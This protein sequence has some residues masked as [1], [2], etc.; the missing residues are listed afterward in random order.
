MLNKL[1]FASLL[2]L[3]SALN[4]TTVLQYSN[5]QYLTQ[6]QL[7]LYNLTDPCTTLCSSSFYGEFCQ[8]MPIP[9]P[10]GPWNQ[11]G[12][13]L[14]GP[15]IF[16]TLTSLSVS[17]LYQAQFIPGSNLILGLLNPRYQNS[18]LMQVSYSAG[19]VTPI[20]QAPSGTTLD[21]LVVRG[22]VA[23]LARSQGST[24]DV[25]TSAGQRLMG[26]SSQALLLEVSLDKGLATVFIINAAYNLLACYPNGKCVAWATYNG[27]T[28][29]LCGIDCPVSVY[30]TFTTKLLKL[31]NT[32]LVSTAVQDTSS[33]FCAAVDRALNVLVYK[34]GN[35]LVQVNLATMQTLSLLSLP[36]ASS[37]SMDISDGYT[38]IMLMQGGTTTTL[39][40]LQQVCGYAQTSPAIYANSS[41]LCTPCPAPPD[42]AFI[43]V[44]SATC[45]WRCSQGY[46]QYG[47]LCVAPLYSPCPAYYTQPGCLPATQPWAPA[48]KYLTGLTVSSQ[49]NW[50]VGSAPPYLVTAVQSTTYLAVSG[51]LYVA[52]NTSYIPTRMTLTVPSTG[53]ICA[54][55]ANNAYYLLQAQ[56]GRLLVAFNALPSNTNCLWS[57]N[58]TGLR[59]AQASIWTLGASVCSVAYGSSGYVYL[60]FCS[61]HYIAQLSPQSVVSPLAGGLKAGYADG[62]LLQ[63]AFN[64]PSSMASYSGRLYVADTRNCVIREVD[65]Y[66]GSVRTVAGTQGFCQRV[67]GALAGL[68]YPANLTS[69]AYDGFLLFFDQYPSERSPTARQ[70]HPAS[71]VVQSIATPPLNSLGAASY[72]YLV[73]YQDRILAGWSNYYF[74]VTA[75]SSSCP[76]GYSA[77]PGNALIAGGCLPCGA[78]SY[79]NTSS[80]A[81]MQCSS[82]SCSGAGQVLT[83]C[84]LDRDAY[85][86]TCSNKPGTNTVYTG[87]S[88]VPA[89]ASG[90]GG[91]CPWTYLPP[92]P[93]GYYKASSICMP[94]PQWS[95]TAFTGA[96][97]V[98]QCTCMAGGTGTAGSCVIPSPFSRTPTVC[99]ALSD[100]PTYTEPAFPF[101]LLSSCQYIPADSPLYV[102]PCPSG[103][104][105]QQIYPKIC[106][107]C[108]PGLFSPL[109]RG[110]QNCPYIMEP[111]LDQ[112]TCRCS[113][114]TWDSAASNAVPQCMCGP[115]M[116]LDGGG[117]TACP[118]NTF[119]GLVVQ[120]LQGSALD[121]L[122]CPAGTFSLAGATACSACAFGEFRVDEDTCQAC[123]AGSYAPD[124]SVANCAPCVSG[125]DG[126]K[127]EACPT[128]PSLLVCSECAPP[129]ANSIQQGLDCATACLDGFYELDY[130]CS[131][132]TQFNAT[133][134]PAG[135]LYIPCTSYADSGCVAC[136]NDTMPLNFAEWAYTPSYPDGPN[137]GCT[138]G[139]VDGYT[140]TYAPMPAGVAQRWECVLTGAWSVWDLFTV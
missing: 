88:T 10:A 130:L 29:I 120:A 124:P 114:G 30:I 79:S 9:P 8:S 67:E 36:S 111:S 73:G 46:T 49:S 53:S 137:I 74:Q 77:L 97:S 98:S 58:V 119:G 23:Y 17:S 43:V 25:I 70:F 13:F 134:C 75:S 92:C 68:A 60:I 93:P 59:L 26:I 140:S 16:R 62:P 54:T 109:G 28:S 117:C 38:Q 39:D 139:C 1:V 136:T 84:Q 129:R 83:P 45:E 78:G 35:G 31:T 20:L 94:C 14:A 87:P 105:I 42:N 71:G 37:C 107:T 123:P 121:C 72:N 112:S 85:C 55:S 65:P 135:S 127:E 126:L 118:A 12:Y 122:P 57:L 34:S 89:N 52:Y 116:M 91:D 131:P 6:A 66:R 108:P 82:P 18:A 2:A 104:Y 133:T 19:T 51:S 125:C 81:C 101:P 90:W 5:Y 48:G 138:W 40:A 61:Q 21:A 102:C 33:I 3:G 4:C 103:E 41:A 96:T 106:S 7:G 63:A 56:G 95:T 64:S 132:C 99:G 32:T 128:D 86:S 50:K 47:S 76:P 115:G 113:A 22:G 11:A 15:P 24:Y 27:A 69:S 80:G 44:G 100:C 110:C